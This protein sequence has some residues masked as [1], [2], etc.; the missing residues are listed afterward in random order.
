MSLDVPM[1]ALALVTRG[2]S[3]PARCDSTNRNAEFTNRNDD[4]FREM[5]VLDGELSNRKGD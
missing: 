1:P 3:S 4:L 2:L 5:V